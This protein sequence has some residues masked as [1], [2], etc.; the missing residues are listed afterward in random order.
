MRTLGSLH[1]RRAR[2]WCRP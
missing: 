2:C 1:G